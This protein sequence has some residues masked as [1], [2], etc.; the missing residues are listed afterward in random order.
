MVGWD[1]ANNNRITWTTVKGQAWYRPTSVQCHMRCTTN[2]TFR[3]DIC[4]KCTFNTL[5]KNILEIWSAKLSWQWD[6]G[7][8]PELCRRQRKWH[9]ES[10]LAEFAGVRPLCGPTVCVTT[11]I[12]DKGQFFVTSLYMLKTFTLII[13]DPRPTGLSDNLGGK[14]PNSVEKGAKK[15]QTG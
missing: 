13:Q 9:Q 10:T 12:S 15:G 7:P 1:N 5:R 14:E 8:T 11:S 2:A 3:N 4:C 6:N